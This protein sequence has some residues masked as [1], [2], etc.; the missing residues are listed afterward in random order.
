MSIESWDEIGQPTEAELAEKAERRAKKVAGCPNWGKHQDPDNPGTMIEGPQPCGLRECP[1]CRKRQAEAVVERLLALDVSLVYAVVPDEALDLPKAIYQRIPLPDG[2]SFYLVPA[3]Q[4][5]VF[6][7]IATPT[8]IDLLDHPAAFLSEFMGRL[9]EGKNKSG[10]LVGWS[11][12]TQPKEGLPLPMSHYTTPASDAVVAIAVTQANTIL[13]PPDPQSIEEHIE[14]I[15][16]WEPIFEE[17]LSALGV[18]F[19]KFP[20]TRRTSRYKTKEQEA[21]FAPGYIPNQVLCHAESPG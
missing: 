18:P 21:V 3:E 4:A 16:A 15:E 10:A 8:A 2:Q 6:D 5:A 12:N 7:G 20:I 9:C 17:R 13:P 19:E 1:K 11:V 14:Y